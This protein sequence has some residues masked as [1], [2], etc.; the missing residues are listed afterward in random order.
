MKKLWLIGLLI[1]SPFTMNAQ[2]GTTSGLDKSHFSK[3]WKVESESPDYKVSFSGDTC[4][5]LSPKGLT[6]WRKEKMSGNVTIEYDACVAA[7]GKPGD[8][9]SDLN[10]FWMASDPKASDIWKRMNWRNGVFV[11]CYS[12]QLYYLGYGG[13]YNST[14]R[15][16]RYD[17]NEAGVTDEKV[18]P[19]ILKEYKDQDNLLTANKWYHIKIQNADNRV[20]YYIDGKL[21]VDFYDPS[22]LTSGWFGFRT[23]LSRTRIT[24]FKY[25]IE[26]EKATE[27]PLHWIGKV[28][29]QARPISFGVPFKQGKIKSG[30]PLCVQTENGELVE[31]D[32]W[33]TAYWP[34]GSVKWAGMAAV[35]PGNTRSV[36]VIPSSKK[37]KTTHTEKIHVTE[38]EDQ[39]TIATGK[40]TAFIPKSGTCI[41]DSLLYG[42]VKVGGKADLIASTQDSPSREDAT[43]IHYQS[44]N[45]LIKK[46]VI[47]QQGKIRTTIKL[48]GVQQGKDGREWLPFTLRMYFY[49]GN[50]QIKMVHSFIYDGDQ[51]KDFIRSLGV[52]FQVPMREDLYNR[53]VAFACADGGVW[54]EPVKPLVGRR[55]LTLDKDQSWQKQQME[56]KRIPEYQRFDAKTE[57]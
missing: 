23:T 5:I 34:D 54:S 19:A 45:S 4:E 43:E 17:G 1:C 25:A 55:I 37:K 50:E 46:A 57:V 8:R 39:L 27:A 33:T 38:S 51:N 32:T 49:A 41:L 13:N 48:E 29:E 26:K 7:E 2:S 16:R 56:G 3:Y 42:N 31:A 47:E 30:T 10:C 21:L 11:N 9:L 12:L 40:I 6:L 35:I 18:R 22:P 52:R 24:N 44:F 53:H 15:F 20:R 36:K 28:P 14:T